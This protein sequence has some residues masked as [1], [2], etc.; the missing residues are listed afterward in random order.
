MTAGAVVNVLAVAT[1]S[2]SEDPIF[3]CIR[4]YEAAVCA[5]GIALEATWDGYVGP[6][7]EAHLTENRHHPYWEAA[8]EAHDEAFAREWDTFDALFVTVPTTIGGVA[9]LLERLGT[10]PY[11]QD[12]PSDESVFEW[13]IGNQRENANQLLRTLATALRNMTGAPS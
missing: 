13:A 4:E 7:L 10:S 11:T 2:V 5:R 6:E 8:E 3:A 9:A 1:G 12:D